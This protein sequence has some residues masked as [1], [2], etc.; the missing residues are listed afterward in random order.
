MQISDNLTKIIIELI[1]ILGMIITAFLVP[2]LME[3]RKEAKAKVEEI[4]SKLTKEQQEE[5]KYWTG[6][7]IQAFEKRY[8]DKLK[9]GLLKKDHVIEFVRKLDF[10]ISD[11]AL[12]HLIDALV[13]ELINKPLRELQAI[14]SV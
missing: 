6:V 2:F 8:E 10:D 11:E 5:L 3:K 12:S 9:A 14:Q 4:Q 7:A 1:G 13:E